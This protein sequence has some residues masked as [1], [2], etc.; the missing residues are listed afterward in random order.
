MLNGKA[1]E[2]FIGQVNGETVTVIDAE[3]NELGIYSHDELK[4]MLTTPG[5]EYQIGDRFTLEIGGE[6]VEAEVTGFDEKGVTLHIPMAQDPQFRMPSVPASEIQG[7][8]EAAEK[9][10]GRTG[11]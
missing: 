11:N 7:M 8:I 6:I 5:A 3:G 9:E 1:K 10:D 2:G 4:G